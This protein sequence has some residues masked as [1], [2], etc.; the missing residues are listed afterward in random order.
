MKKIFDVKIGNPIGNLYRK[1]HV[2][3]LIQLS[4][5]NFLMGQKKGFYPDN[6]SRFIGG[7]VEKGEDILK[8]AQREVEEELKID[9][10]LNKFTHFAEIAT[11]ATTNE[12]EMSMVTNIFGVVI[13]KDLKLTASDDLSGVVELTPSQFNQL[14]FEMNTLTGT[15]VTEKF[16]FNWEDWGKIYGPIHETSMAEFLKPTQKTDH[17]D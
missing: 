2:L 17:Q 14:V 9:I 1:N 5:G 15:L 7:G 8:T 10:N 4:N 12:G 6:I 16:S 11:N 13:D 3:V